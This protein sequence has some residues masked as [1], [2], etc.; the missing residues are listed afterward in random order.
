M[1]ALLTSEVTE[2][3]SG[4]CRPVS[5]VLS[6]RSSDGHFSGNVVTH[7]LEQPTRSVLVGAGRPSLPI[8]PCSRWGLPCR[9]CHHSRGELLPHRF[10]L[11]CTQDYGSSAVCSLL[12]CPSRQYA[13]PRRYLAA[14]PMEPGL[15]SSVYAPAT[16]RPTASSE[17]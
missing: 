7:V 5:R 8:W 15:S 2:S 1:C 16:I 3:G 11:A 10:T 9:E 12:H 13:S 4:C 17:T 6:S 14:C